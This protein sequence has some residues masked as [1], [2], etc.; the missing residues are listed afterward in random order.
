MLKHFCIVEI[1]AGKMKTPTP[2]VKMLW[3]LKDGKYV[4][5]I[6]AHNKRS[7]PQNRYYFGLVIP[8]IQE[9]IKQ[10]GTEIT[11]EE[12]HEFL[13]ARFNSEEIVN[14][15]TGEFVIIPRSTAG[16]NKELFS[17]YIEKVH[18]F[19]AEFLSIEI[20]SPGMQTAFHYD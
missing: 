1:E 14:T 2:F 8:L 11:K 7:N 4:I 9:G 18:Q 5:E 15:E 13:K 3:E 17:A 20:P 10:L 6:A 16:L 19:A 12:C